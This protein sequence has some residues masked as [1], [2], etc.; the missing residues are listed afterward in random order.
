LP[1]QV[2]VTDPA[3]FKIQKL[4]N[5]QDK[6]LRLSQ[7]MHLGDS[8][9]Q[10]LVWQHSDF[11]YDA[12]GR[13]LK[14]KDAQN[15]IKQQT[16][17]GLGHKIK[18]DDLDQGITLYEYDTTGKLTLKTDQLGRKLHYK[19]DVAGRLSQV[20]NNSFKQLYQY[21][22]D[23]PQYGK[24]NNAMA[25][26]GK[27]AW[28]EE[29]NN[30]QTGN[31]KPH[32][33]HY[34][35]DLR[36]NVIH[37][38]RTLFNVP[39]KFHYQYD[40]Q[41][42]LT[43]QVFPD[44]DSL[45][46]SYNLRGQLHSVNGM[47]QQLHYDEAG[48]LTT[49]DYSNGT[50]Q[51]RN[52][53]GKGQLTDLSSASDIGSLSQLNYQYDGRGNL[54][55]IDNVLQSSLSQV[56]NYDATSQLKKATGGYGQL[57]YQYDAI[58]N[59]LAK[60]HDASAAW[61]LPKTANMQNLHY[62]GGTANRV[63]KGGK[64]GPHAVTSS[65]N[66]Y[67]WLYNGIGQREKTIYPDGSYSLLSWDQLG[68]LTKWEKKD[69]SDALISYEQ[70]QYDFKGR[71]LYKFSS[72][73]G[74]QSSGRTNYY[75]DKQYEIRDDTTQK[76]VFAGNLRLGRLETP[77]A[78]A[79]P[80]IK[81]YSLNPGW[82]QIFL[83]SK[84][85]G[86]SLLEQLG[87]A[88]GNIKTLLN[89]DAQKQKYAAYSATETGLEYKT[90]NQLNARDVLWLKAEEAQAW[91]VQGTTQPQDA[92]AQLLQ[93]G[94]NQVQLPIN[95]TN[96]GETPDQ[97]GLEKYAKK[98]GLNKI[99]HYD[100]ANN[101]WASFADDTSTVGGR[102]RAINPLV[103]INP[104][105]TYWIFTQKSQ[106][107][108]QANGITSTKYFLHNN[109]LGSVALTTDIN[110]AVKQGS[111]YLPYGAPA[112]DQNSE[113]QPYGFSAKER[114][115]SELMY[116]EAR[117]YDP[118]STRFI[119]PDPLFAAEMEKCIESIVEC[120]LYQYTGN[121]PVNFVDPSGE[122]IVQTAAIAGGF[123]IGGGMS[124]IKGE[125]NEVALQR[126]IGGALVGAAATIP[127][128]AG[129]IG[130]AI[131]V[132]AAAGTAASAEIYNQKTIDSDG[133][134]T[135]N[136]TKVMVEAGLGAAS[137]ITG[138][139]VGKLASSKVTKEMFPAI[140]KAQSAVRPGAAP[141]MS[142]TSGPIQSSASI[143]KAQRAENVADFVTGSTISATASATNLST[144]LSADN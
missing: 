19:Y 91:Q 133:S 135:V 67:T 102:L 81:N 122:W 73:V 58:G 65:N 47:V 59:I 110:G 46:Y 49:L 112:N 123:V 12:V 144:A 25:Y 39:Y 128:L 44:G 111:R 104:S 3:G 9:N 32:S 7:Q 53:D 22:Y 96:G 37:K 57:R 61:P 86:L 113:L 68:R 21:H 103:Q 106:V 131:K 5:S 71:R 15:N 109:H 20:L 11:T 78:Q 92:V 72:S 54:E 120:N 101:K 64:T 8:Q 118:L 66:G 140:T 107:L 126:A 27:L 30:S 43:R 51:N 125:S 94:W 34:H 138:G 141:R 33:E 16:F 77:I 45:D 55:R 105:Q 115:A 89:F 17:N 79:L 24:Q 1:R 6:V 80:Q 18:Q 69:E 62:A 85:D 42:R 56:F 90:L 119:S 76:H 137:V 23:A 48:Q 132:T 10:S 40:G 82:N 116:F 143:A 28:V 124:L 100:A 52:Y 114:D 36:G 93:P 84:P 139:L 60:H 31:G 117:Y 127:G 50:T 83:S 4:F 99:W 97:A 108:S 13:L 88:Q 134:G 38:Q 74:G 35:Y 136:L 75:V 70:Y 26:K 95:A 121:N 41:D 63:N 14:I 130:A 142:P 129:P 29:F 2:D 98:N 87:T